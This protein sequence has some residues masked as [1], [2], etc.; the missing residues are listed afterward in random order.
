METATTLS[1]RSLQYY[2]IARHWASDL[3]FFKTETAFFH[4]LLDDYIVY[5]SSVNYAGKL[6]IVGEKLLKLEEE[7]R[8]TDKLLTDQIKHLELM[9][10]DVI[11]EDAESLATQQIQL[12]HLT[13]NLMREY[14]NIKK[15]LFVLVES[16]MGKNKPLL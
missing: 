16:A 9:A 6:K 15:Q 4:R 13:T 14:R 3:E 12:E 5:L 8:Q 1:S 11:P 7:E 10:E 2:V